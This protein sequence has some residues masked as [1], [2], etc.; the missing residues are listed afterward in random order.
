MAAEGMPTN[1]RQRR[2]RR[3]MRRLL[4]LLLGADA[5]RATTL[6]LAAVGRARVQAGV[7]L[8]TDHLV[9]VVLLR[10][11]AQRRLNDASTQT[12]HQVQRRLLLD[13]VVAER[14]SIL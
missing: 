12:Q 2:E 14:A 3:P 13:V 5:A 1:R 9:T 10:Q 8:A 4:E 6:L 7:A 11:H